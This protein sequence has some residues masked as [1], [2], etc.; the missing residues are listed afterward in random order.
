[1][2]LIDRIGRRVT[3]WWRREPID[4]DAMDAAAHG[5]AEAVRQMQ[6]DE[7][8]RANRAMCESTSTADTVTYLCTLHPGHTGAHE[9]RDGFNRVQHAWLLD[10]DDHFDTTPDDVKGTPRL[11][12]A[13]AEAYAKYVERTHPMSAEQEAAE[14]MKAVL[15]IGAAANSIQH[16]NEEDW[17]I[18]LD[19]LLPASADGDDR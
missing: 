12:G 17:E 18:A 5:R 16:M 7:A 14:D 9:C 10:V 3:E 8:V 1:M 13:A 11:T 19:E 4:L 6:I 2:S 15:E